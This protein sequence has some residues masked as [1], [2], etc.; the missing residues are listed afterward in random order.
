[1][2]PWR[3]HSLA[4][5]M[6][7]LGPLLTRREGETWAY[8]LNIDERHLNQAG[9]VHG[10]TLT[11]LMD[12]ALSALAWEKSGKRPCVTVQLNMNFLQPGRVGD[13]LVARGRVTHQSGSML[14]LDGDIQCGD[15]VLATGQAILKRLSRT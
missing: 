13:T 5:L 8:G 3:E 10:G 15:T 9:M 2:N 11:T 14:F 1:M 6:G 12:Q 4:G 7:T